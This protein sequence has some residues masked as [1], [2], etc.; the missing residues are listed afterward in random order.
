MCGKE[1]C[2]C[3]QL[4]EP[5]A[6]FIPLNFKSDLGTQNTNISHLQPA[7]VGRFCFGFWPLWRGLGD[8]R[9]SLHDLLTITGGLDWVHLSCCTSNTFTPGISASSHLH[10]RKSSAF[11]CLLS[12]ATQGTASVSLGQLAQTGI[13]HLLNR[14]RIDCIAPALHTPLSQNTYYI[15]ASGSLA[16]R[17]ASLTPFLIRSLSLP[18]SKPDLPPL[19]PFP[20]LLCCCRLVAYL[21]TITFSATQTVSKRATRALFWPPQLPLPRSSSVIAWLSHERAFPAQEFLVAVYKQRVQLAAAA[22]ATQGTLCWVK[23]SW[24]VQ[25]SP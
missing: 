10:A 11:L 25:F 1:R 13:R 20:R 7:V 18:L 15:V 4:A 23:G 19:E 8:W 9:F 3:C 12:F 16:S 5:W 14:R 22:R 17:F 24:L 21:L 6:L 2:F